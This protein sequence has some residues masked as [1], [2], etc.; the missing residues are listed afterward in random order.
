MRAAIGTEDGE[1]R[2]AQRVAYTG[3][4]GRLRTQ[5]DEAEPLALRE[6]DQPHDIRRSDRDVASHAAGAAVARR[7]VDPLDEVRLH[8]FPDQGVLARP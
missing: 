8:A 3:V 4:H 1:A 6:A 2:V 7:A 5:H